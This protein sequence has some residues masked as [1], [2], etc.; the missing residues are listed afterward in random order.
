MNAI[1][2]PPKSPPLPQPPSS[3]TIPSLEELIKKKKEEEAANSKPKFL[4]KQERAALALE[5]RSQKVKLE[6]EKQE[7]GK[8]L[9]QEFLA[10]TTEAM[11]GVIPTG[12]RTRGPP[13]GPSSMRNKRP[14]RTRPDMPPP[15]PPPPK[16]LPK[17]EP[18]TMEQEEAKALKDK[19]LGLEQPKKKKRKIN[20]KKFNFDWDVQDDTS[21]DIN[22][23]YANRHDAQFYGRGK[24]A[25]FDDVDL[26]KNRTAYVAELVKDGQDQE[27]TRRLM[28]L[29]Q[30]R[31]AKVDWQDRPWFEKPLDQM[32]ERDWRIFKEDFSIVTKGGGIPN[33]IRNW[34]E[35]NLPKT[36]MELIAKVGYKEPSPI[37][38]AAIPIGLALRDIIGIAE[39]GSGKTAA[40]VLPMLSYIMEMPPLDDFN[41]TNG[42]YAIALVPT[43]ELAQQIELE[44]NKF[45]KPVG[46]KCV[47][48][49]GGHTIEE[50][51]YN[52]REGAEIVIA[53]PG[54]LIDCLERRVLVLNQCAYVVL[55]EADRM[56]DL[57]FEEAVQ[58]ILEALPVQNQKPD[59]EDAENPVKMSK[60]IGG[61]ERYRQT[62]MFSATMPNSLERLARKYLRRPAIVTIG[63]A[64]Q[65]VDTVEQ[66]VE[67][68]PEDKKKKR[69]EEMLNSNEFA[70]PIIIFVNIKRNCDGLAKVLSNLGWR[71][72]T[73]HGG[74][75]Q[76]QREAAL[77]QLRAGNADILVATDLAGRGIDVSDVSLVVNYNMA[78]NIEDY[79]HRIGRT[80]RAGKSGVAI[81]LLT[82][83]DQDTFFDLRLMLSKSSI[84]KVPD[85]LRNHEAARTRPGS[86]PA[87]KKA[88]EDTQW[89]PAIVQNLD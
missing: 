17:G 34:K 33:P 35:S 38:R 87:Q 59:T 76:D 26:H 86:R 12:P 44:A 67:F 23:L 54:R 1:P 80:G 24:L 21:T 9:F 48:I 75:S 20:D 60:W 45:A 51:A 61:K 11:E 56:I 25:G 72:V 52:L 7:N 83:D 73:L 41:K 79:T 22:P 4:S 6:R 3:R 49:V 65:A 58:G 63:N 27:R 84:S 19:Y 15:P 85:E 31:A 13:T 43:R 69:L 78:K 36:I 82:N 89:T 66:R 47:S 29:E 14:G 32:K 37:Q 28:E 57:G 68:V 30:R 88:A 18:R 55:D 62:V 16:E 77:S 71:A 70:A 64:G 8:K 39:T 46:F 74:K 50:Q 42:P 40:F 81:T 5:R 2:P 53:T 10:H